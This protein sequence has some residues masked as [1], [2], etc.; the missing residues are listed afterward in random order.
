MDPFEEFEF[1][2]LTEGLGFHK[3]KTQKPTDLDSSFEVT[4]PGKSLNPSG[5]SLLEEEAVD[6]LRPPLPRKSSMP[7][8]VESETT[9]SSSAVD[10]ILKTLQK[11][12][13]L[14]FEKKATVKT[15][16]APA[17]KVDEY[18]PDVWNFSSALLDGML[19]IAA[20]LL[21]MIIVLIVTK[22]DLIANLST[23]D[24]G[25]M[26][27]LSTFALVATVSFIYLLVNR[28]FVGS[29]PG[30]WAFEQRIGQPQE[31]NSATYSLRILARSALVI[32]T[33]FVVLPILSLILKKDI[34]GEITGALLL[35]KV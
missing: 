13:H 8:I 12:R 27:Y 9:P 16:A 23:P 29:T 14:D 6:P 3:K 7:T 35:K 10:E 26:I 17:P 30:E 11:N 21:C 24:E 34:A 20:S 22:A 33:G 15:T 1:K 2:P 28:I 25:G 4:G 5:L 31:M 18:K 19:V 32:A